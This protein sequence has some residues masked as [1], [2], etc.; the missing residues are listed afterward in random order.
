MIVEFVHPRAKLAVT[1]LERLDLR[2]AQERELDRVASAEQGLAL[3]GWTEKGIDAPARGRDLAP[4]EVDAELTGD[5]LG[6]ER[7][8]LGSAAARSGSRPFSKQL[9]KKMSPK[10][11][12]MMQ[13]MP[14]PRTAQ[15]AVSRELPHAKFAPASK[16]GASRYASW[17]SGQ[18]GL[19][20]PSVV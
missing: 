19:S 12:A 13:R 6:G 18:S 8:E 7:V 17:L 3:Q 14:R 2:L 16:I 4:L 11:G 1:K 10:L 5:G 15:T 20:A 9:S